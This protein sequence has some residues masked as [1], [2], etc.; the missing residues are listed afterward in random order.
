MT[1]FEIIKISGNVKK[2]LALSLGVCLISICCALYEL[3]DDKFHIYFFDV[4]QGDSILIKTPQNH[5]ILIDG[6]PR[7][8]VLERLGEVMPFL[9]KEIDFVVLTHTHADHLEGLVEVLKRFEVKA[10]LIT[11]ASSSDPTYKEFLKTI[12]EKNIPIYFAE[13]KNDFVFGEVF[14]DV[15]YPFKSVIGENFENINNSSIGMNIMFEDIQILTLGDLERDKEAEL[16]KRPLP[17]SVNIYKASHHGSKTSSSIDFLKKI[18]PKEVVIQVGEGNKFKHPSPETIRNL[19]RA[20]VEK[21]YR[22]DI[23][24]TVKFVF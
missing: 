21:I 20:N 10:V 14:F 24:G 2:L 4:G 18:S 16:L 22:N 15:L 19:H 23:E 17:H 12:S 9:D 3:P 7:D 13:R 8:F 11:G 1:V 6:G 5:K